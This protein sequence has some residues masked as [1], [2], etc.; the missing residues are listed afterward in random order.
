MVRLPSFCPKNLVKYTIV[1]KTGKMQHTIPRFYLNQFIKP[2]WAYLVGYQQP[3]RVKSAKNIA[4]RN[5]YYSPA[6]DGA[7]LDVL[8][9]KIEEMTAPIFREL[10]TIKDALTYE[11][12]QLFSWFIANLWLRAPE[13]IEETGEEILNFYEQID[14]MLKEQLEQVEK[15]E[16]KLEEDAKYDSGGVGSYRW[17][18]KEW[19]E[20]LESTRR[21]VKKGRAMMTENMRL[22]PKLAKVI[23]N[24]SWGFFDAPSGA[25]FVTSDRPVCL[26]DR[27]GSRVGAGWG[28]ANAFGTLPLSPS[29]CLVLHYGLP[30]DTWAYTQVPEEMVKDSNLR[31]ISFAKYAV[32]SPKKYFPAQS[33]LHEKWLTLRKS[34][35]I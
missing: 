22:I 3:K 4:V 6:P 29:R 27:G 30:S 19:K 18:P 5:W 7:D 31:T 11:S 33:W 17:T 26:T 1:M 25:F 2:G 12:K 16:I 34:L 20:E 13:T 14:Y 10:L 35:T 9:S 24:M 8:N 21:K 23:A 32:Y 28:N 15:G